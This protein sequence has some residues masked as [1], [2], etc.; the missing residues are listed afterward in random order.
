M[1]ATDIAARGIDISDLRYVINYSLP[2]DP[3]VYLHRVGRTGRIGKKG[4]AINLIS[5]RELA[6][7]TALEKK[8]GIKFEKRA[9]ADA[10]GGDAR[11]GP[12][13][14]C[15]RSA[16]RPSGE[17]LRGLPR[18][19]RRSSSSGPDADDSDR[20]PAQ[21][22]LRAPADGEGEGRRWHS[23][24]A[25]AHPPPPASA[26]GAGA[27]DRGARNEPSVEIDPS[28]ANRRSAP[29]LLV[30]AGSAPSGHRAGTAPRRDRVPA[31]AEAAPR[32]R[33]GSG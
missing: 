5:G 32:D 12:S 19:G 1:V 2:E 33:S 23:A 29:R 6:T 15:A 4:T 22:L 16:R 25:G 31:V 17:R 14:T 3:A 9:D 26:S 28:G 7:F 10:G 11:C 30:S 27:T 21:V 24:G 18:S 13:A 20:L 8:Y